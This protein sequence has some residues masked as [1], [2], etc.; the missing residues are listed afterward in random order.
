MVLLRIDAET[1]KQQA[2]EIVCQ[3]QRK[4]LEKMFASS[5]SED[6]SNSGSFGSWRS[7]RRNPV[8]TLSPCDPS[9]HASCCNHVCRRL[10]PFPSF[11][12]E[13]PRRRYLQ[14]LRRQWEGLGE[15]QLR[16]QSRPWYW[17]GWDQL[18][19]QCSHRWLW[20]YRQTWSSR[21]TQ[22]SRARAWWSWSRSG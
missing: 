7:P 16:W 22:C 10:S 12:R 18:T 21:R 19:M 1:T 13:E 4:R 20:A 3:I 17:G 2:R 9:S 5:S 14:G 6:D 8:G 15:S 11:L